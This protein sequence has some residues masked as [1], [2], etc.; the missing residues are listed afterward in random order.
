MFVLGHIG[1]GRQ[2]VSR[3]ADRL[4]AV[5]LIVGILLP[6]ILDKPL[7]YARLWEYVSCTRTFGHTGLLLLVLV[8]GAAAFRSRGVAAVAMGMAT[9]LALDC[10]MDFI[11]GGPE[12]S[13]WRAL[14]WPLIHGR[15]STNPVVMSTHLAGLWTPSTALT[16]GVG[17]ALLVWQLRLRTRRVGREAQVTTVPQ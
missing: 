6:D 2:L 10:T 4:P 9:H 11:A 3:W 14:T 8:G 12:S 7:Y 16:E 5:P 13:A 17:L 1:I 15:F